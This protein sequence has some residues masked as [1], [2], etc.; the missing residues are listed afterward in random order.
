MSD[1]LCEFAHLPCLVC[2]HKISGPLFVM[3]LI[4]FMLFFQVA[5]ATEQG[6]PSM[7]SQQESHDD[8][9]VLVCGSMS[10]RGVIAFLTTFS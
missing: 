4:I 3:K 2:V 10:V 7:S 8:V 5:M 1:F 6:H 9:Q